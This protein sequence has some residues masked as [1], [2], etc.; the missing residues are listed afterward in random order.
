MESKSI[1][2]SRKTFMEL[3]Q[4]GGSFSGRSKAIPILQNSLV[5]VGGGNISVYSTDSENG[6]RSLGG[7]DLVFSDEIGSN[8]SFCVDTADVLRGLKTLRDSE[9]DLLLGVNTLGVL[10]SKG[11]L[12]YAV[13]P[14]D[15]FPL[16][17]RVD[18]DIVYDI[19]SF[20]LRNWLIACTPFM[21]TDSLYSQLCGVYLYVSE[22]RLGVCSTDTFGLYTDSI[23]YGGGMSDGSVILP[24]SCIG[25]LVDLLQCGGV[26]KIKF[27]DRAVAIKAD[28]G[29]MT[30][31]V[32][33]GRFPNFSRIIPQGKDI[34]VCVDRSEIRD[35][36]NRIVSMSDNATKCVCLDISNEMIYVGAMDSV[37]NKRGKDSFRCEH[38]GECIKIGINGDYL[39]RCIDAMVGDMIDISFTGATQPVLLTE[40][41]CTDKRVVVMPMSLD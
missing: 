22:G 32:P 11:E 25:V 6:I 38:I 20:V 36:I 5:A 4:R 18:S 23:V 31:R 39:L 2:V 16:L 33:N 13:L 26:C 10:H 12:Q 34:M 37:S 19:D 27:N 35:S 9:V 14:S 29:V 30:C 7:Y 17:N 3:L 1:R 28:A 40:G 15:E 21:S 8:I 24:S 41:A